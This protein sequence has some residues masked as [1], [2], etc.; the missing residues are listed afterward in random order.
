MQADRPH[1]SDLV[2]RTYSQILF[3]FLVKTFYG[4]LERHIFT[5]YVFP[6]L[7]VLTGRILGQFVS[8]SLRE[9]NN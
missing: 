8:L 4:F 3:G 5:P 1:Q 7:T 9:C 2:H 6:P